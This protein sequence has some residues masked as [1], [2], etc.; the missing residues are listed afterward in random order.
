MIPARKQLKICLLLAVS[1]AL[2]ACSGFSP[3]ATMT[4]TIE[5]PTQ[6]PTATINWFPATATLTPLPTQAA[7]PTH[8]TIPGLGEL[9][10][11]DLF[12]RPDLWSP[13]QSNTGNAIVSNGL[14]TLTIPDGTTEGM[15]KILRNEPILSDFYVQITA[16]LG[17]C[18]G[19]DQYSLLFR[20]YSPV[21]FYRFTITCSG[22]FRLERVV[23]GKPFVIKDWT[24]SPDAPLGAP[25]KVKISVFAAGKDLRFFLNDHF[26]FSVSDHFLNQGTLGFSIR[27]ESGN[28]L[29]ISFSNLSV[30]AVASTTN[31]PVFQITTSTPSK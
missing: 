22:E 6:P 30:Y 10:F 3:A 1:V 21:D 28:P 12:T 13:S 7:T 9:I 29:T 27:S 24:I 18:R 23:A 11:S 16:Q 14:L 5:L 8:E 4:P 20:V 26:Q 15:V 19:G 17:L 2:A 31:T 25:G